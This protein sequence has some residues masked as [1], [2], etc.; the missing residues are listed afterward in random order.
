MAENYTS[1][2]CNY[3]QAM[4][5]LHDWQ[6]SGMH[7]LNHEVIQSTAIVL[8]IDSDFKETNS[9]IIGVVICQQKHD[10]VNP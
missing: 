10:V 8:R 2:S 6:N 4:E 5:C 7:S 3:L 1:R 9:F